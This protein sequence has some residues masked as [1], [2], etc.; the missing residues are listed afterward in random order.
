MAEYA[1]SLTQSPILQQPT[2]QIDA[3]SSA[4][5]L[6]TI[7]RWGVII[8]RTAR[9]ER[10]ALLNVFDV[11][12]LELTDI[13]QLTQAITNP[14]T[15]AEVAAIQTKV[16]ECVVQINFMKLKVAALL[17]GVIEAMSENPGVSTS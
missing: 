3:E 17:A 2:R 9:Q 15:Q 12:Q 16:N 11:G 10:Q 6:Q 13:D 7:Y 14:P 5:Y 1:P 4:Q 8:G